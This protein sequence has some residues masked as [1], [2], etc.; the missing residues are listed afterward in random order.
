MPLRSY[1]SFLGSI[2]FFT[3]LSAGFA[4]E[5]SLEE[6]LPELKERAVVLDIISRVVEQNQQVVWNSVNSKVTIHG[7][8]VGIK[9]VGANVVMA[10]QFTPFLRP[11]GVS[12]LVAQGQIWVEI[13]GEGMR[14]QT[15]LQT[16]PIEFGEPVFFFP[17]G[18]P[19]VPEDARIELQLEIRPYGEVDRVNPP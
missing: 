19:N 6:L 16:I 15:T 13:P 5:T 2:L 11:G 1:R 18:S 12:I 10:L 3:A 8:P 9:I 14:Y 4:Q 7:R 17:L